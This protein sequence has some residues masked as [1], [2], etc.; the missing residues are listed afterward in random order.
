MSGPIF[1][2]GMVEDRDLADARMEDAPPEIKALFQEY[3]ETQV[4]GA[5]TAAGINDHPSRFTK[6]ELAFG[7]EIAE[8]LLK[9]ERRRRQEDL[10]AGRA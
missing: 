8:G 5:L 3:D 1:R 10:L 7:I 4:L 9:A 6:A 2:E